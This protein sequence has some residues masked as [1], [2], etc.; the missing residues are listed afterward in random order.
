[1]VEFAITAALFTALL[2]GIIE[3]GIAAWQKNSVAADSREGVRW[4][5]VHGNRSLNAATPAMVQ[6]YVKTRTSLKGTGTDSI[7][8]YTVWPDGVCPVP[9]KDVGKRVQVS[10]AHTVPR[11]GPFIPTHTDSATATLVVLF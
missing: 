8:V 6:A 1:M 7:R 3:A 2:L 5:A 11:R 4:A 10:V 9:C